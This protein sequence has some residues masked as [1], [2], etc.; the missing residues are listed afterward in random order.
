MRVLSTIVGIAAIVSTE[1]SGYE[2]EKECDK[3]ECER[4]KLRP[5]GTIKIHGKFEGEGKIVFDEFI[6]KV[7][8]AHGDRFDRTC[9]EA[10]FHTPGCR[11]DPHEHWSYCKYDHEPSVCFGL[12]HVPRHHHE[13]CCDKEDEKSGWGWGKG[14]KFGKLCYE[15]TNRNCPEKYPVRCGLKEKP[16][17]PCERNQRDCED[18][19]EDSEY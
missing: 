10:C 5:E 8:K 14:K 15:P 11:N 9:A 12:Y 19:S 4:R 3:H 17:K 13:D 1:G 6:E 2:Y 16:H 18:S 7:K